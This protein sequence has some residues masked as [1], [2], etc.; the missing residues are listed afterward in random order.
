VELLSISAILGGAAVSGISPD[1]VGVGEE[2]SKLAE[3]CGESNGII[4][5][6]P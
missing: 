2:F 5:M 3:G 1:K 4:D 6:G